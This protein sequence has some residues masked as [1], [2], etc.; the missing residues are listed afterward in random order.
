MDTDEFGY[1]KDRFV[2]LVGESFDCL[3]CSQVVRLPKECQ[4][5]G[6]MYCGAC[7]DSWL[8]KK[9]EC[10]NRCPVSAGS[11][12]PIGK[13]LMRI[14][15]D[16]DIRC[17]Y[18]DQ[19]KTV[20]KI[21]DLEDH[22]KVCQIPKCENFEICG[23]RSKKEYQPHTVCD[24]NCL[25]LSK[26]K[27][28]NGDWGAVYKEIKHHLR[29]YNQIDT[30]PEKSLEKSE[31]SRSNSLTPFAGGSGANSQNGITNFKWDSQVI[32][33]GIEV[34]EENARAFLKEGPYMF[35]TV[36]G[37]QGFTSGIHY[38]ELQADPRTENE[39]KIGV[40]LKK[41]FN[42]NSAFCDY[43]FGYAYY[44]LAQLR[45]GSN[46]TGA[47][48]GKKFKKEGV[49]GIFLDMNRGIL[50]FALNNE[51]FGPAFKTEA[52]KKGPIYPAISLLH[53]AG[54]KLITGKPAPQYF[55]N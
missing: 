44:G 25:L 11:I 53:C 45:A 5:C 10:P 46:A 21:S 1:D 28:S 30:V 18:Y 48:Y 47:P 20:L 55:L 6:N 12:Q 4:S 7:I 17:K 29:E 13:A 50:S 16:L 39:I 54:C 19:C 43:E 37:D 35:R 51:P 32:G 41:D 2:N 15:N 3:I 33:T 49:L 40:S 34:S 23:N 26:I 8:K 36:L 38:W 24:P 14:Y 31:L 22:E 42:L 27:Q 9:K 52:L